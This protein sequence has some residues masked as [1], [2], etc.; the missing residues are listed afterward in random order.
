MTSIVEI[1]NKIDVV[2]DR[3][4]IWESRVVKYDRKQ[5]KEMCY[6]MISSHH[7]ELEKLYTQL[8]QY[9]NEKV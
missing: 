8:N 9:I 3:L 6:M 7:R 1:N 2:K 5:M 4:K